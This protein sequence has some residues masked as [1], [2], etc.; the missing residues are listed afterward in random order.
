MS[1]LR[2]MMASSLFVAV[3][4]G[5]MFAQGGAT[6]A[7]GGVV[8]DASGAVIANAKVSIKN[9]ATGEVL[10]QVTS[11]ASGLFTATLLPGGT[12]TVEVDATG[13]PATKF[14]GVVVRITETTRMT[15]VVRVNT[16]KEVVEVQSQVEQVNTTDA[17]T[18]QSLGA[19][20]ITD[21]PLATRNFQQLFVLASELG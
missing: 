20:T 21:L 8:Q 6:G 15:A 14:P 2:K 3:F 10:R 18:G 11:D 19:Q 17:T 1:F 13:F 9:E 7:I 16:V 5:M 4:A 12:Y